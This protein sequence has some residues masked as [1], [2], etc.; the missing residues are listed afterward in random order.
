[1]ESLIALE[2]PNGRV[3]ETVYAASQPMLTGSEFPMHGRVWRVVGVVAKPRR[4]P[5]S[6]PQRLLCVEAD[7]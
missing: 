3:H 1:M 4:F 7:S 6:R 2:Y 5:A